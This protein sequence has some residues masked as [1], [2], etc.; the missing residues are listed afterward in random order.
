MQSPEKYNLLIHKIDEFIRRYY[1]HKLLRGLIISAAAFLSGYLIM[2]CLE[3]WGEFNTTIRTVLFYSYIFINTTIAIYLITPYLIGYLRLGKTI[4]HDEAAFIIGEHFA[5][6]KDKL[7]NTLQLKKM[8]ENN[9]NQ[10]E[11]ITASIDQ[12]TTDLNYIPFASA[13]KLAESLKYIKWLLIP[14]VIILV[15]MVTIPPLIF[16]STTRLIKYNQYFEPKAPFKFQIANARLEVIQ[17]DDFELELKLNGNQFPEHVYIRVGKT[18]Y[19]MEKESNSRFSYLLLNIQ[20]PV[21]FYFKGGEFQSA[22][23]EILVKPKPALLK[24]DVELKYPGYLKKPDETIENAGDLTVPEG[25]QATFKIYAENTQHVLFDLDEQRFKVDGKNGIFSF[26]RTLKQESFYTIKPVNQLVA[27][28][29]V[30]YQLH[31]IPDQ[32]PSIVVEEKRDSVSQKALY[33]EGKIQDDYG[34]SSLNFKYKIIS[35]DQSEQKTVPI[36]IDIH[37][38]EDQFFYFWNLN[39]LEIAAGSQ[40]SY[41]FEVADNDRINGPKLMRSSGKMLYV[42]GKEELNAHLEQQALLFKNKLESALG[43]SREVAADSKKTFENLRDKNT[44]SFEDQNQ[45]K[46]VLKKQEDLERMIEE[47]KEENKQQAFNREELKENSPEIREK[48]KQIDDLFNALLNDKTKELLKKMENLMQQNN[49][50]LAQQELLQMQADNKSLHKELDRMLELYKQLEFEQK[51]S[52]HINSLEKLAEDQQKLSE[53]TVSNRKENLLLEKEQL[54][55]KKDFEALKNELNELSEKNIELNQ[56]MPLEQ[57][58]KVQESVTREMEKSLENLKQNKQQE[59][60]QAQ[61]EAGKQIEELANRLKKMAEE[62]EEAKMEI[63]IAQLRLIL[64]NLLNSSF[65][66]EELMQSLKILHATDP[67]YV[68]LTREQKNIQNNLSNTS[69][70][71]YAISK[72]VPQIQAAV[73]HEISAINAHIGQALEHLSERMG[74]Q[75]RQDQQY[76]MTAMNNLAILLNEALQQLQNSK[77]DGKS[78]KASLS[79]LN[80]MQQELNEN[81]EKLREKLKQGN[82]INGMLSEQMAKMAREQQIIRQSLEQFNQQ[83]NKNAVNKLGDLEK[84]IK[85]M[86]QTEKDIVNKHIFEETLERQREIKIKMLQAEHAEQQRESD[87]ER[88]SNT[89]KT[90]P[91][92]YV[93]ALQGFEM[94]KLTQTEQLQTVSP[95]LNYFYKLKIKS[96][97][98]KLKIDSNGRN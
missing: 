1:M 43:L 98:D 18:E 68:S 81:M 49:T 82:Q 23:Y 53:K 89:G 88:E 86:E 44:L 76:A 65:A 96:Y 61:Q 58:Q 92:G 27:A 64:K 19:K 37:K 69:D 83:Q 47:I 2:V 4:T 13:I 42:P 35:F 75:A 41:H 71:L 56:N 50:R 57:E 46:N 87:H 70:S 28:D 33:F 24:F 22:V 91:P 66:Q 59:A 55:I 84:I 21:H 60:Q 52:D 7:L 78:K 5:D 67:K 85:Q 29:S 74:S 10:W 73:N 15:L 3:Y 62:Q 63:N 17:G 77:G 9:P 25:T 97:F 14:F 51:L 12:K 36:K 93:K 80:Q 72:R 95:A 30:Q 32:F 54:Q 39:D 38:T 40:I 79:Q 20:K 11:L 31:I 94:K 16:E 6:V 26:T 34:F 45:V 90:M 8:A 48:Q